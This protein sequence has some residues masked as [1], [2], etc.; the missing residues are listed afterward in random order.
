MKLGLAYHDGFDYREARRAYE[1]GFELWQQVGEHRAATPLP[2]APHPLR[3]RWL[4]PT[5][6][7]PTMSPDS[8][9]SA[10]MSQLF[11]GLVALSPQMSIVPDV[12]YAWDVSEDGRRYIFHLRDDV[13]WSDGVPVTAGDFEYAWKRTLAPDSGSPSAGYLH[14]IRGA[15]AFHRGDGSRDAVGVCAEDE[16]TLAVTLEEPTG[17]FLQLLVRPDYYPL[18]RHV[19]EAQG[20]DW[21]ELAHFVTN[22]PF[23]L[24]RWQPGERLVLR[25]NPDYHGRFQGN[26]EQV[27]LFPRTDWSTRLQM[28]TDDALDVLGITF[29]PSDKREMA[30]QRHA[31]ECVSWP[32]LET[33]YLVFDV[34][35]PPFDDARV[36]RAFALSTDRQAIAEVATEGHAATASGGLLPP[37]MP[38]HSPAIGLPYDPERARRLLAEAG[39]PE[40]RGFPAVDALAFQAVEGRMSYLG[41]QWRGTLDVEVT[42]RTPAWAAFLDQ[43]RN[44]RH[45]ILCVMWVADYPD[46]DNFM[47]VSRAEVWSHWRDERYDSLVAEAGRVMDQEER[48][49]L[50]RQADELLVAEAPIL[51]LLYERRH[52]LIKPWVRHY[53]IT[54]SRAIFWKDVILEPHEP[55]GLSH[56]F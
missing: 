21:T 46:P 24:E 29:F 32:I 47:R 7:D 10:L 22:G 5:T 51:P 33:C 12:A 20:T 43:L 41:A 48:M 31:D 11:S 19:V 50:Y 52:L 35:R 15:E 1:A 53:P 49:A 23:R 13:R 14:A 18:P 6:M 55:G 25:R 4:E 44:E 40:G 16:V 36:R 42:W 26:V 30:R 56:R 37:G 54:A 3:V 17:Y 28:Y 2:P 45:H 8:H 38:G 34:S 27:E 9:T 39:Y